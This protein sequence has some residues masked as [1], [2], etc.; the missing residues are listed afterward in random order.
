LAAPDVFVDDE[1]PVY[2]NQRVFITNERNKNVLVTLIVE[3]SHTA[4]CSVLQA[5]N[6]V[7]SA[8]CEYHIEN[9]LECM[10]PFA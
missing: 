2:S 4:G 9:F 5:L 8:D 10:K 1:K 7:N 6:T 3:H